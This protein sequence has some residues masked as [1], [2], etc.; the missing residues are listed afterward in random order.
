MSEWIKWEFGPCPT[1]DGDIVDIDW[2]SR[3][4]NKWKQKEKS[5]P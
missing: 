1:V 5:C 3:G 2:R 4:G